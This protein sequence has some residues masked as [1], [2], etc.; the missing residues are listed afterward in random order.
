MLETWQCL[1]IHCV[2]FKLFALFQ[3]LAFKRPSDDVNLLFK[4]RNSKVNTVVHHLTQSFKILGG[5]VKEQ[6]LGAWDVSGPIELV[7]LVPTDN[8]N[9]ALID[10]YDFAFANFLVEH[11]ERCPLEPFEIVKCM[12]VEFGKIK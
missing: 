6:N 11:F 1:L 9:V 7:S 12:L 8:Q 10:H 5:D 3:V 4:L 2:Y